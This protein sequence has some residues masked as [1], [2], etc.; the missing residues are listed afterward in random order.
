MNNRC[1]APV[2]HGRRPSAFWGDKTFRTGT[3]LVPEW[4]FSGASGVPTPAATLRVATTP[5]G[6]NGQNTA[7]L[8][9]IRA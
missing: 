3:L 7:L 1:Q 4:F 9:P 2:M 5:E 6:G 8:T